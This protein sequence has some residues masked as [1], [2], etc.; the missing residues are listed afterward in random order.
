MY[1]T[2]KFYQFNCLLYLQY[3]I[4]LHFI[5]HLIMHGVL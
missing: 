5:D 3:Y 4:Y 1:I 2:Y